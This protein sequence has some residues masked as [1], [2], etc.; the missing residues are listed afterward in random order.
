MVVPR[1]RCPSRGRRQTLV[2]LVRF[3]WPIATGR[4]NFTSN[5]SS[6]LH[7][8]QELAS[9]PLGTIS[10]AHVNVSTPAVDL[11]ATQPA[12]RYVQSVMTLSNDSWVLDAAVN[13]FERLIQPLLNSNPKL[14]SQAMLQP[15]PSATFHHMTNSPIRLTEGPVFVF[16]SQLYLDRSIEGP[17][18]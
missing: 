9:L 18:V 17:V 10:L 4:K 8:L 11:F 13:E 14:V 7:P 16:F 3:S 5:S 15:I 12:R 6:P 1:P 2:G